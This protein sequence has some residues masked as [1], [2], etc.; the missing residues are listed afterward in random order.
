MNDQG[1]RNNYFAEG[2]ELSAQEHELPFV[3]G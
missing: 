3:Q 2:P 1:K